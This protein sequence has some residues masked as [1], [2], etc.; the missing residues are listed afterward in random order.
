MKQLCGL[1][2]QR[3]SKPASR[4]KDFS[5]CQIHSEKI[6]RCALIGAYTATLS[7]DVTEAGTLHLI[8]SACKAIQ[9][10]YSQQADLQ[11][12]GVSKFPI[13]KFILTLFSIMLLESITSETILFVT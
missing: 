2:K 8:R 10:Q 6:I 13:A 7:E 5:S 12:Q 4:S 1:S 3:A 11:M 9:K